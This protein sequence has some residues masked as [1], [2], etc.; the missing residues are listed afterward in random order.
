MAE[1][2]SRR[3]A[4]LGWARSSLEVAGRTVAIHTAGCRA[5]LDTSTT[6]LAVFGAGSSLFGA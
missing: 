1:A 5:E 6:R 3:L 4:R 2:Q